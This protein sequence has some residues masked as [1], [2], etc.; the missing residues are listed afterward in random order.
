[1]AM[2]QIWHGAELNTSTCWND[3][4]F[5]GS[6]CNNAHS[7]DARVVVVVVQHGHYGNLMAAHNLELQ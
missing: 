1:M 2:I 7:E 3:G 4:A 5:G 6:C